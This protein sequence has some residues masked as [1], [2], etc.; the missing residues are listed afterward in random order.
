MRDESGDSDILSLLR[1][2][3]ILNGLG[4]LFGD[5]S[6]LVAGLAGLPAHPVTFD[7]PSSIAFAIWA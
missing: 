6:G 5:F 7:T 1:I 2:R 3:R 4:V